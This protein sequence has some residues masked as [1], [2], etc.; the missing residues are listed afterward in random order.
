MNPP[1]QVVCADRELK[2]FGIYWGEIYT[3]QTVITDVD[4]KYDLFY[5]VDDGRMTTNGSFYRS[6]FY[7]LEEMQKVNF[8]PLCGE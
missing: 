5:L 6:R 2:C 7:D 1:F 3:V 8:A 4:K